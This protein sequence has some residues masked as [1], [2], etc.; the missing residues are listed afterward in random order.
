MLAMATDMPL[1]VIA[2]FGLAGFDRGTLDQLVA[3]ANA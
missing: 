3:A 2:D 1:A